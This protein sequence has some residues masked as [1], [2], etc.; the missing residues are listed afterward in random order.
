MANSVLTE[1]PPATEPGVT[2]RRRF[3][4]R[5]RAT[6]H[7]F[8]PLRGLAPLV[9][10]LALWQWQGHDDSAY[11]PP[12]STWITAVR[13]LWSSGQL[14]KA[15]LSTLQGFAMSLAIATLIGAAL[16]ALIGFSR[17]TDRA[18]SPTL[19]YLRATPPAATL[20]IAVLLIGY[21]TSMKIVIV[22]FTGLWPILL[23]T[24]SAARTLKPLL[25]D[26][27]KSLHLTRWARIRKIVFPS[28]LPGILLGVRV[29]APVAL[30]LTLLVEIL[31]QVNGVGALIATSQQN[32]QSASVYGLVL[33]AG[34]FG[35][36]VN[37]LVALLETYV[38]RYLPPTR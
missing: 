4:R 5:R 34:L 11:Y 15:I 23:S 24:R 1:T 8:P 37:A 38:L 13:K 16:G 32:F 7:R 27:A 26:T 2:P 20:P 21:T 6:T 22:V 10:A 12:P 28:V 33:I 36:L 17:L 9:I 19:E 25:L 31:T 29:A 14:G 18:L 35:L 3:G 30:I